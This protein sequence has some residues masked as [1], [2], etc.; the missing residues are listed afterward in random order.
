MRILHLPSSIGSNAYNLAIGEKKNGAVSTVLIDDPT[1]YSNK[2]DIIFHPH[3]FLLL[4]QWIWFC[5]A[6]AHKYDLFHYNFGRGLAATRNIRFFGLDVRWFKKLDK[7]IAV[8]Y[9]GNDARQ[10]DYCVA[11]YQTT[12]FTRQ[13]AEEMRQLDELKRKRIAFFDQHADLIYATNPDLLNVL[14]ERTKFR[15]YTKLQ[16]EEWEPH[17]S[18]YT[19]KKTVILHAPSK[20][21][22][23]GTIYINE[24]IQRLQ[25]EGY[26]IEYLLL[27][28]IPNSEVVEY[29]KKADLVIDQLLV[30]WYGGFAVECMALG[31][32]VMCYIRESDMKHIP[33]EM[34]QEMPIIRI[35]KDNL[36]QRMKYFLDH[37]EQLVEISFRSRRY[38]E[39]W[40]DPKVI[41]Q[42]ILEDY[43][44]ALRNK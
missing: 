3:K 40:H 38:V 22:V 6:N 27:Q 4:F 10:A 24:A 37:K 14:P 13:D 26:D 19:K 35:T 31:K 16:P 9:Q 11:H 21:K 15:P 32:P 1:L 2:A 25:E 33:K 44:C 41:A 5:A 12:H 36:Y 39:K 28:N 29:Y 7:V 8:T 30:G 23:K 34:D 17:Y 18:D 42:D 20:P 43:A